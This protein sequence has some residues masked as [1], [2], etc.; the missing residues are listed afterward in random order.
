MV[1]EEQSTQKKELNKAFDCALALPSFPC[2]SSSISLF[3]RFSS[4][5]VCISSLTPFPSRVFSVT[6]V[7]IS[8]FFFRL[9]SIV[10][11]ALFPVAASPV[12]A[13]EISFFSLLFFLFVLR[14]TLT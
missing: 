8:L 4:S 3:C 10:F 1:R 5:L 13:S 9:S 2:D 7:L 14:L 6:V 11:A 12:P